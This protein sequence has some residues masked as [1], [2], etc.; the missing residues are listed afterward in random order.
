MFDHSNS[1]HKH[2][3]R[4]YWFFLLIPVFLF[5]AAWI[6]MLLW[7]AIL[8]EVVHAGLITYWQALGL[9]V[10]SRILFGGFG[11]HRG[12]SPHTFHKA[13]ELR[14]KWA[15]MSDEEKQKFKEEFKNRC[16]HRP[17]AGE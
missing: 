15:Q 13:R 7:N 11:H 10:L 3:K 4:R 14:Q 16:E 2:Y 12:H 17:S 9:L 5:S 1:T 6:V 8:P